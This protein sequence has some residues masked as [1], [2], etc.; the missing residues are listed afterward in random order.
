M[1]KQLPNDA[2]EPLNDFERKCGFCKC[3]AVIFVYGFACCSHHMLYGE[4]NEP[5]HGCKPATRR[6][7]IKSDPMSR[8]KTNIEEVVKDYLPS[9]YRVAQVT[10]KGIIIEGEDDHGWTLDGYVI[11]RLSSG[12]IVA[13]EIDPVP[14]SDPSPMIALD[15]DTAAIV[16]D[17]LYWI[18]TE[19]VNREK[20]TEDEAKLYTE[21]A[22]CLNEIERIRNEVIK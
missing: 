5:C 18:M 7:L 4:R 2:Y 22:E 3:T 10:H 15:A 21:S 9:N 13:R 11:P 20:L 19:L 17:A 14:P 1:I 8:A 12:L 16:F 6:A